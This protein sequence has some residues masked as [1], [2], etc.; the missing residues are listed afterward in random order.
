MAHVGWD[1]W[2][3]Q[4]SLLP[5]PGAQVFLRSPKLG[6]DAQTPAV[7]RMPYR[8]GFCLAVGLSDLLPL[9]IISFLVTFG[10]SSHLSS[11]IHFYILFFYKFYILI[12][13]CICSWD[14]STKFNSSILELDLFVQWM[15]PWKK[16]NFRNW[17][18]FLTLTK[19]LKFIDSSSGSFFC[20]AEDCFGKSNSL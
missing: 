4:S 10:P 2:G 11:L 20:K 16:M 5:A 8:P 15:N 13:T 17:I 7:P 18:I 9:P 3:P 12:S 19:N 14:I 6:M 1:T